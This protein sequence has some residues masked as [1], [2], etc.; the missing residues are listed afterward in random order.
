MENK[1]SSKIG[2]IYGINGPV[3]YVKGDSGFQ[4]HEMVYVGKENLIGEVISLSSDSTTI[5][6]YEETT[7][8]RPGE[9]VTGSGSPVSLTLAPGILRN[10]FDGIERPLHAIAQESGFYIS[11]GLQV[12][13]LDTEK[14]WDTHIIVEKGERLFPGSIIA[15]VPETPAITHKVMVPPDVEGTVIDRV[16]DGKYTINDPLITLQMADGTELS[17]TMT[18]KWPIRT[19]RPVFKRFPPARP[20]ITGQRIL[21]TLFPLAK[22]GTAA[23]PGG[24]GTGKTMTQHQIAK[25]SDAD[26]IIY[27]GCGERGNEMTQVLEEFSELIDPKSGNP[28]M[29]RTVLIANTSNMPVA[30]REAS[31]YSGLTLAEYYR[32]MGYHV[33]IMADS[34]SRWAEALRELSGR[35][36]E[37]PAEEGFPAYLASRLSGFYERAGMMQN[38]NGTEGS[39]SIIGAVSP[40]GGDFSEPVTQNTKR[41]VRCFWGLDKN[42]AYARHFPAIQWLTSYS[43]YLIDLAPWYTDHVDKNFIE[44][45]NRIVY[46]LTQESNLMEIVK[47]IGSD[48]LPDDQKLT[49]EIARVIR[50]GFLQQNAFHPDDTCVPLSKQFKMMEIILYLY[51]RSKSLISMGMPMSVLR[52]DKIFDKIIS[53]KYDIPNNKLEMFDEYKKMVDAFYDNVMERNA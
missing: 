51:Q 37:M 40:Q 41:F 27:I 16:S 38:L 53:I 4:M 15:E 24:F 22:G 36:E 35:L 48:V 49:L 20:L 7:G 14:L 5:Q 50:V 46:I 31:L 29:D 25:W 30:A 44:F 47:L 12:D 6:V 45:R 9:T 34:T 3:V 33:A 18:Q 26:I 39:V 28:L 11:R 8:I 2:T 1:T 42:L 43:E 21:D 52:E 10:I 13:S 19:A 17:L 23:I 32:D